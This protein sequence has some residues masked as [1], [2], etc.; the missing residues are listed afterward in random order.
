M[1]IEGDPPPEK[2]A[3]YWQ[4]WDKGNAAR[5]IDDYW[6]ASPGEAT[7]RSLMAAEIKAFFG[8]SH[9]LFEVGCGTGLMAKTLIEAEATTEQCYS[10]GDVSRSMLAIAQQRLP[11]VQFVDLDIFDLSSLERKP[12]VICLHVL[13]HLPHYDGPL[14]QLVALATRRLYIVT[15]F[16]EGSEDEI[17]LSRD[18]DAEPEFH[19]NVYSFPIFMKRLRSM[20]GERSAKISTKHLIA[21]AHAIA[22]EFA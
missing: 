22:I 18:S 2:S 1:G 19:T 7:S 12:N 3:R 5:V 15:W 17:S 8:P 20:I 4:N 13:Q 14:E 10:G 21:N 11:H 16:N 9:P 6:T